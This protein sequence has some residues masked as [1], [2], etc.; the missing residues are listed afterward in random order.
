MPVPWQQQNQSGVSIHEHPAPRLPIQPFP[1]STCTGWYRE[2]PAVRATRGT[3]KG[4]RPPAGG[5][6]SCRT[7]SI[8]SGHILLQGCMKSTSQRQTIYV[9]CVLL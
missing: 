9:Q 3:A 8:G 5:G 1:N 7:S 6:H 2:R 4:K